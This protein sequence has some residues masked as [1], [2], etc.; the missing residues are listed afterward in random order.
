MTELNI[1]GLTD[2]KLMS[3]VSSEFVLEKGRLPNEEELAA[4]SIGFSAGTKVMNRYIEVMFEDL[5]N[6]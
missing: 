5:E 6:D 1:N 4:L 2:E 3:F